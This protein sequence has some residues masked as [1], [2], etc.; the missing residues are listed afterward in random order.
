MHLA[1]ATQTPQQGAWKDRA[2]RRLGPQIPGGS[3][4]LS[5]LVGLRPWAKTQPSL[6]FRFFMIN[7]Q[8]TGLIWG[9]LQ[10]LS[11]KR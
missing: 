11:D 8:R 10:S 9:I 1:L 4:L 2:D 7:S 3:S 5:P 6:A